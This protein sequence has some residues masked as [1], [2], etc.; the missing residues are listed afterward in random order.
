MARPP[1]PVDWSDVTLSPPASQ[2]ENSSGPWSTADGITGSSGANL[3][4]SRRV[5]PLS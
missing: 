1:P 4:G 2:T 5:E 3:R